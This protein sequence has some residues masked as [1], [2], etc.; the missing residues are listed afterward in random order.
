M[1]VLVTG[2][3]GLYGYHILR[4]FSGFSDISNIYGFDDFSRGFP[5]EDDFVARP[6]NNKVK[7]FN[8]RFQDITVKEIESLKIDTVIHLAG[9]NS[10]KESM[11]IPEEYFSINEL[12]TFQLMQTLLRTKN[13]PY[14]LYASTTEVYGCSS[15][16]VVNE[17]HPLNPQSVYAATKLA[18]EKH[19][20]AMGRWYNYPVCVMRFT[21]TFGE[22]QNVNGY[23][24]AVSS[25]IDRAL[26]NEPL[27][28]YGSGEQ[29]RDFIYIQ[30]V[31]RAIYLGITRQSMANG[32]VINIATGNQISINSFAEKIK[33]LAASTSEVINLPGEREDYQLGQI[34]TRLAHEK[35]GWSAV[36][37]LEQAIL[38]TICW[39]K[40]LQS[41]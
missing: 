37:P 40:G 10:G 25:F 22:N 17:I 18:A 15:A 34:E 7:L 12:G 20:L 29:S 33:E 16:P 39:H 24:S 21:N 6:W 41:I 26:R 36:F 14:L 4:E 19:I 8:Q 28:I 31:V 30:D 11:D 27:I 35:L 23:T 38:Q 2:A 9:Y 13:R 3:A 1:R 5:T 32:L